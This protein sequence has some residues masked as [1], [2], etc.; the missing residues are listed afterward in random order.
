MGPVEQHVLFA[1]G[2]AENGAADSAI[3]SMEFTPE[4]PR[5]A[6][7]LAKGGYFRFPALSPD[8]KKLAWFGPVLLPGFDK[9]QGL[10]MI[11]AAAVFEQD[12]ASGAVTRVAQ[13]QY[14]H[15]RG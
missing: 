3:L 1:F 14:Q 6:T 12:L 9:P 15:I 5:P 10:D 8:G 2:P 7:V 13:S 11:E 4:G